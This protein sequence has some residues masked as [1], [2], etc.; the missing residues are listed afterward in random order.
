MMVAGGFSIF[1]LN[2]LSLP[3][4]IIGAGL[5][6]VG[7][8]AH[9]NRNHV[10]TWLGLSGNCLV[11]TGVLGVFLYGEYRVGA[12][13]AETDRQIQETRR[14]ED[15]FRKT[16]AEALRKQEEELRRQKELAWEQQQTLQKAFDNHMAQAKQALK[17]NDL[18]AAQ[19]QLAL[20][21]KYKPADSQIAKLWEEFEFRRCLN[22]GDS[23]L[24]KDDLG[25]SLAR[26]KQ[27]L[28]IRPQE[29]QVQSDCSAIAQIQA[30]NLHLR[31]VK[32]SL[33]DKELDAGCNE[34]GKAADLVFN[35]S[36]VVGND[37]RYKPSVE[38]LSKGITESMQE[39]VSNLQMA[40]QADEEKAGDA[41]AKGDF[42]AALTELE[43]ASR[44]LALR[45]DMLFKSSLT[46]F[47]ANAPQL[48]K[49]IQQ[50]EDEIA[51]IALTTKKAEGQSFL[52]PARSR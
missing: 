26:F 13:R 32:T 36:I 4:C 6:L 16:Q 51:V 45:K 28:K 30:A 38:K 42:S 8:I 23:F 3:L 10:F 37:A 9:R 21:G 31:Q 22:E 20:A 48:A 35:L 44:H 7:L 40:S 12:L 24:A 27:A 29:A 39:L 50:V 15:E 14:R 43:R 18:Q 17:T 34:G 25:S 41:I 1:F 49:K 33:R 11:I 19:T 52:N 46:P 47:G 2:C 5:G